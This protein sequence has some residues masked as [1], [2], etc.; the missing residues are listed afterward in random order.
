MYTEERLKIIEVA[1]T[2]DSYSRFLKWLEETKFNPEVM[3]SDLSELV[4][5]KLFNDHEQEKKEWELSFDLYHRASKRAQQLYYELN[6]TFPKNTLPDTSKMINFL[7]DMV[8]KYV[9][10]HSVVGEI[11]VKEFV[12]YK[13][14]GSIEILTNNGSFW[15]DGRIDS[16]TS[17]RIY[18]DNLDSSLSMLNKDS[19]LLNA[20]SSSLER[21]Y[22]KNNKD[23]T[24][25]SILTKIYSY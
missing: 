13:D 10:K 15:V 18:K 24:A 3:L 25:K 14:G 4:N 22:E 7:C 1:I 20:L 2:E 8:I 19:D 11:E 17:G 21:F 12:Y 5:N 6:P 23:V 9:P 16:E